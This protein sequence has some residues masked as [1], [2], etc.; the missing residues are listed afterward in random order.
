M[1][2]NLF[3]WVIVDVI[4]S[5]TFYSLFFKKEMKNSIDKYKKDLSKSYK[6]SK[7]KFSKKADKILKN[8]ENTAEDVYEKSL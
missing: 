3:G 7:K 6:K 2:K 4:A 5:A 1:E 8:L